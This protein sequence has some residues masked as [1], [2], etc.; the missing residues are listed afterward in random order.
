MI[1]PLEIEGIADW[2]NDNVFTAKWKDDKGTYTIRAEA[3]FDN[4]LASAIPPSAP[5]EKVLTWH[6]VGCRTEA[7]HE[8]WKPWPIIH[9][10][11]REMSK[12][13]QT[14]YDRRALFLTFLVLSEDADA[15]ENFM[16]AIDI[17]S[18]TFKESCSL[19]T[20]LEQM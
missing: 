19:D 8:I 16:K 10:A 20:Y 13:G 1:E 3:L 18:T 9:G 12:L 7:D 14:K 11:L 2:N 6:C 5:V 15:K 4:R 17:W